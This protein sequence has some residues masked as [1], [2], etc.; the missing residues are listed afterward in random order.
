M[1]EEQGAL[2]CS[3]NNG[4]IPTPCFNA[5]LWISPRCLLGMHSDAPGQQTLLLLTMACMV[6]TDHAPLMQQ[7]TLFPAFTSQAYPILK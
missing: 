5:R 1:L 6:L 4:A 3:R 2:P 7:S